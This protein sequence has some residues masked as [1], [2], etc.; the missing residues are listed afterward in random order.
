MPVLIGRTQ[1]RRKRVEGSD[2]AYNLNQL[3]VDCTRPGLLGNPFVVGRDGTLEEVLLLCYCT[4]PPC[5]TYLI[6][7]YIETGA[8][9]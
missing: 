2:T 6:K 9:A 3:V 7:E 5:H 1:K 4:K 8:L